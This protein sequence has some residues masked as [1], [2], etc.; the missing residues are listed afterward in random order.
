M[1][2]VLGKRFVLIGVKET[3]T[4]CLKNC[5]AWDCPERFLPSPPPTLVSNLLWL[6]VV[7]CLGFSGADPNLRCN[8]MVTYVLGGPRLLLAVPSFLPFS[9]SFHSLWYKAPG[10]FKGEDYAASLLKGC[11]EHV[12]TVKVIESGQRLK[13]KALEKGPESSEGRGITSGLEGETLWRG[14]I[15]TGFLSS[16]IF[17]CIGLLVWFETV[18]NVTRHCAN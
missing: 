16:F 1:Y 7:A 17:Q 18:Y 11:W 2:C 10:L 3:K 12:Y 14:N 9:L 8:R 13:C 6:S 15:W 4:F 5:W